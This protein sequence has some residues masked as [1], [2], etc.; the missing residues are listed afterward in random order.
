MFTL[1][2]LDH[3]VF[4]TSIFT[5]QNRQAATFNLMPDGMIHNA[6]STCFNLIVF[7][8]GFRDNEKNSFSCIK[9][10]VSRRDRRGSPSNRSIDQGLKRSQFDMINFYISK[11]I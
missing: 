9:N 6:N 8:F 7:I 10:I 2:L 4:P 11:V 5:G 1:E 3:N